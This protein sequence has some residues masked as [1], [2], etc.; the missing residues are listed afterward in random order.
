[1]WLPRDGELD[2]LVVY[3]DTDWANCKKTRKSCACGIFLAGGCLLFSYARS[4]QMICLSSGE[5]EFNGGVAACSEGIFLKEIFEFIGIPMGM[6]VYLDSSA[7]RGVFQ[8]QGVG[9]IRHL[10]VKGLWVQQALQRKMFALHAVKSAD[11]LADFGTKG[12]AIARFLELRSKLKIGNAED[13]DQ[14]KEKASVNAVTGGN[15]AAAMVALLTL[16]QQMPG[17]RAEET[18]STDGITIFSQELTVALIILLITQAMVMGF[19]VKIFYV[20]KRGLGYGTTKTVAVQTEH[21]ERVTGVYHLPGR[22]V[23]HSDYKCVKLA[24]R[25][26]PYIFM[27]MCMECQRQDHG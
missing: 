6:D 27:R 3:S 23:V 1:M 12:L 21:L 2:K 20:V 15:S 17:A 19:I 4:L 24:N 18:G 16:L 26:R 7:A 25:T 14:D 9:R 10:E 5:A 8:R 13:F 22:D 11:N